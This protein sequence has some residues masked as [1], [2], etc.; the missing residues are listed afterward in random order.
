M[1]RPAMGMC[2]GTTKLN[3]SVVDPDHFGQ[4]GGS[5]IIEPDP[6]PKLFDEKSCTVKVLL[7]ILKNGPVRLELN[8]DFLRESEKG[9]KYPAV[10]Q[11][12]I[13]T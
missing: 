5:R 4:V 1:Q 11:S 10:Q 13:N 2:T 8:S 9:L 6:D 3:G 12:H 7:I